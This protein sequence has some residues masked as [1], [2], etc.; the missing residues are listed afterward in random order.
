M[1]GYQYALMENDKYKNIELD[2][3]ENVVWK[4]LGYSVLFEL[5]DNS[6]EYLFTMISNIPY[7]HDE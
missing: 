2:N 5:S 4:C 3:Q 7:S 6:M 1:Q